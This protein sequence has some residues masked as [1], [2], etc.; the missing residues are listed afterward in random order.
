MTPSNLDMVMAEAQRRLA[1]PII[2]F[3][4]VSPGAIQFEA[5]FRDGILEGQFELA[6]AELK[7]IAAKMRDVRLSG[8]M[9]G[10]LEPT[11]APVQ[12][13]GPPQPLLIETR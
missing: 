7:A 9:K 5:R 2:I 10:A 11:P 1:G 12:P 6:A 13:A 3:H 8:Q 4:F